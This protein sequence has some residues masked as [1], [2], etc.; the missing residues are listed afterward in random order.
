MTYGFTRDEAA[1]LRKASVRLQRWHER[2]CGIEGG[3]IERDTTTNRP[4]WHNSRTGHLW[5]IPDRDAGA[6]RRIA[7]V[8]T[9]RN[10]RDGD[11]WPIRAYIQTDPRGAAV[12]LLTPNDAPCTD[13]LAPHYSNGLAVY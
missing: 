8:L 3:C 12:W 1:I 7:Q 2:E 10:G 11:A 9:A 5:P 6:R 4:M 13:D